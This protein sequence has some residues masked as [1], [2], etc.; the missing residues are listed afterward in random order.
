MSSNEE[1]C[2]RIIKDIV[3]ENITDDT[4]THLKKH[5]HE[6]NP[7]EPK[8]FHGMGIESTLV[9]E[10]AY[11]P[12]RTDDFQKLFFSLDFKVPIDFTNT[13]VYDF[14]RILNV[15]ELALMSK[16]NALEYALKSESFKGQEICM[17]KTTINAFSHAYCND[18]IKNMQLA[19][20]H[21]KLNDAYHFMIKEHKRIYGDKCEEEADKIMHE[22]VHEPLKAKKRAY[23]AQGFAHRDSARI[24]C[25]S[26]LLSQTQIFSVVQ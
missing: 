19:I 5:A 18:N 7:N 24:F 10:V 26:I 14:R 12:I 15:I 2:L 11:A 17:S 22:F 23:F 1:H 21:I 25:L 3:D 13:Y 20:L 16:S 9:H 8:F 6:M 4:I